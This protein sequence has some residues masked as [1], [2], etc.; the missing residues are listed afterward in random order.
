M[1]IPHV[2]PFS[3]QLPRRA[4]DERDPRA[5]DLFAPAK[6]EKLPT[7]GLLGMPF[8]GAVIGRK[9]CS[10]GPGAVREALRYSSSYNIEDDAELYGQSV[11]D[12][13]DLDVPSTDVAVAHERATATMKFLFEN[14][15]QPI[16]IG[17]D[18]SLTYANVRALADSGAKSI[19]VL[20]FDAHLDV[21]VPS[22]HVTSG[23]P[24][25]LILEK[26]PQVKAQ[27]LVVVGP[28][29]F[30]NSKTYRDWAVTKGMRIF[31]VKEIRRRGF[32]G[33]M[34]AA[35]TAAVDGVDALYVSLDMDVVDQAWAPGVSSPSPDGLTP[36]EVFDGIQLA[37]SQKVARGFEVMEVAPN[38]DPTG[39]TARVG[40]VSILQYLV[41]R[42]KPEAVQKAAERSAPRAAPAASDRPRGPPRMGGGGYGGGPPRGGGGFSRGP[43]RYGGPPRRPY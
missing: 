40:A 33:L 32:Q 12:L 26:I 25:Y 13:G 9:G 27:N 34:E 24:N 41:G 3:G 15:C 17:G 31:P 39:N 38:L 35:V 8:D 2:R 21:R 11:S 22:P 42:V 7:F 29:R 23:T 16:V 43:S 18:N 19:G 28:R 30:A 14:G 4:F 1:D 36:R 6:A 5:L 20:S 37:A 10:Q